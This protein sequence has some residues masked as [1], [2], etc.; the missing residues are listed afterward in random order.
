MRLSE[1]N[2]EYMKGFL[3]I[4]ELFDTE[5]PVLQACLDSA[6]QFIFSQTGLTAEQADGY[7]DLSSAAAMLAADL[8]DNRNF[9]LQS[10]VKA[11]QVNPAV[12]AILSQYRMNLM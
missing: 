12:D 4:D 1:L 9:T 10:G 3:H 8:F 11:S 5:A 7:A 2:P 6:K